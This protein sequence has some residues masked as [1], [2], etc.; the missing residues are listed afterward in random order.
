MAT[1]I[2]REIYR[3]GGQDVH[4][5]LKYQ[6]IQAVRLPSVEEIRQEL[7]MR[8]AKRRAEESELGPAPEAQLDLEREQSEPE[9]L[10]LRSA[11]E[12]ARGEPDIEGGQFEQEEPGEPEALRM[13]RSEQSRINGAKGKGPVTP[14]GK[15]VCSQNA[16]KY[17]L[18]EDDI[19]PVYQ[20]EWAAFEKSMFEALNPQDAVQEM[21]V[22]QVLRGAWRLR[23]AG[24]MEVALMV[25]NIKEGESSYSALTT[26]GQYDVLHVTRYQSA[27]ERSLH[28]SLNALRRLQQ[29]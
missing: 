20:A 28:R 13:S 14:E 27:A 8:E 26:F 15:A 3:E 4:D 1:N 5:S 21:L 16:R 23:Q 10:G 18:T 29:G 12:P 19:D 2:N 9:E 24:E 25:R 17:G 6:R 7:A 22:E 11:R